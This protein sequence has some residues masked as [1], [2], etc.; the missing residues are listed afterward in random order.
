MTR[1]TIQRA[2]ILLDNSAGP[3]TK[4]YD[5][6]DPA[7]GIVPAG[8]LGPGTMLTMLISNPGSADAYIG[9]TADIA[10]ED[11]ADSG[12][13]T[14]NVVYL[15]GTVGASSPDYDVG[16]TADLKFRLQD[17]AQILITPLISPR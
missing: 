11:P 2:S 8:G 16:R 9:T 4:T 3:G 1:A 5:I 7:L 10:V 17:G 14:T 13:A 6:L 12:N 15:A